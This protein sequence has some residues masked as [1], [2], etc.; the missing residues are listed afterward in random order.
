MGTYDKAEIVEDRHAK[1][2]RVFLSMGNKIEVEPTRDLVGD[3][4][5]SELNKIRREIN[6]RYG[7]PYT[8]I[9]SRVKG[10]FRT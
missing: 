1:K 8:Q 6:R 5:D 2:L 10:S 7:V 4:A 3:V 9:S